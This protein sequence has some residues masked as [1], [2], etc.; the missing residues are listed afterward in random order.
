MCEQQTSDLLPVSDTLPEKLPVASS[1]VL[2][3]S[4]NLSAPAFSFIFFFFSCLSLSAGLVFFCS[5]NW[6]FIWSSHFL[7]FINWS[8]L[9][10]ATACLNSSVILWQLIL[11]P[12]DVSQDVTSFSG[13]IEIFFE[14]DIECKIFTTSR[15]LLFPQK[16][17]ENSSPPHRNIF[18]K[19]DLSHFFPFILFFNN[20]CIFSLVFF[21]V[22]AASMLL[23][24]IVPERPRDAQLPSS[25]LPGALIRLISSANWNQL[26]LVISPTEPRQTAKW[27]G[28]EPCNPT[29][30][31][32]KPGGCVY[33][34]LSLLQLESSIS[35][36][37]G[38]YRDIL[39]LSGKSML[40]NTLCWH[41]CVV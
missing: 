21:N 7:C 2:N 9:H 5:L 15:H 36:D 39:Q 16:G 37:F 30:V 25:H 24:I 1:S 38:T 32:K 3:S 22:T 4:H 11:L 14:N 33:T 27:E 28:D 18:S 10:W 26:F 17:P 6:A 20:Y 12:E 40:E 8:T 29:G 35:G 23:Q 34:V 13:P 41:L 19:G 31:L